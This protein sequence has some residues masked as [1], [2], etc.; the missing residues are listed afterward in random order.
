[1]ATTTASSSSSAQATYDAI[2]ASS[3]SAG[4][5]S[6]TSKVTDQQNRFLTL[7]TTQLKNQDPLNPMDNAQ[8]TS[9][10]A[11]ISTVDGIE[12]LNST[13]QNLVSSNVDSQAMQA[14]NLKGHS[15]LTAG[16]SFVLSSSIAG[17]GFELASAA[18]SV[19]VTIKD[20]NGLTVR[21]LDLG[22]QESGVRTFTW[23]GK[24]DSGAQAVDGNYKISV[25]ATQGGKALTATAL[26]L[27]GVSSVNTS[28][29]GVTLNLANG[30]VATMSEIRQ[31]Y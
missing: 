4:K 7:L 8:V 11:Q 13:L 23:D 10:L 17:G 27:T 2:N 15:V 18:D 14:A 5:T 6:T 21:T 19:K 1:M 20:S 31:I 26:E 12:R 30:S 3:S 29:Q 9:Q 16:S 22:S 25:A 24:T 28:S